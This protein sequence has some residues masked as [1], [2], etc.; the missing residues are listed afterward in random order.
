[1]KKSKVTI[2]EKEI[3]KSSENGNKKLNKESLESEMKAQ[4]QLDKIKTKLYCD[5]ITQQDIEYIQ[6]NKKIPEYIRRYF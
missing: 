1:M 4:R 3:N 2:I 6:N 5:R